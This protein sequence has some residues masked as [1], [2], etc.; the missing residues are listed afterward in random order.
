MRITVWCK[1]EFIGFHCWPDAPDDVSYLRYAHR[2]L[3]K[4][5]TE[6]YVQ[7]GDRFVEFHTLKKHVTEVVSHFPQILGSTSCEA[8][9]LKIGE[10]LSLMEY[11]V[12]QVTVSEDGE[13]GGTIYFEEE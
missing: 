1:S 11:K 13:C 4:V 9:A 7:H 12:K 3:F 2:H 6:V 10:A 5:F 8:M